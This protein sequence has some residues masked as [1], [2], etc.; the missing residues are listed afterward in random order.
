[1]EKEEAEI[2]SILEIINTHST[3][4]VGESAL[5]IDNTSKHGIC[6]LYNELGCGC[7]IKIE[8]KKDV[9]SREDIKKIKD[10]IQKDFEEISNRE[11][12]RI[13]KE[14]NEIELVLYNLEEENLKREKAIEKE[15]EI[16]KDET[17]VK[18]KLKRKIE[19]KE[20]IAPVILKVE[21][22]KIKRK[23][24]VKQSEIA[25]PSVLS[26]LRETLLRR[27]QDQPSTSDLELN[28]EERRRL[29]LNFA[30]HVSIPLEILNQFSR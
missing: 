22:E 15:V 18:R 20:N 23:K 1:M 3:G 12:E 28:Q 14:T 5:S 4:E 27:S 10:I 17:D 2:N 8:R 7:K 19:E 25:S 11:R 6:Y 21:G 29:N 30:I 9:E 13:R 26:A 16:R 24:K